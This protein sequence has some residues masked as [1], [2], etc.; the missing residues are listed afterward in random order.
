M[1][2]I[3]VESQVFEKFPDFA[4]G[5]IIVHDIENA[6]SNAIIEKALREEIAQEADKRSVDSELVRAW[7]AVHIAF[8]SNPNKFPPSIKS[9]LKRIDKKG[10]IPFINSA[11]ALFNYISIKYLV[12]CCGDDAQ[13][14][15]GNLR[16]GFAIG[17][18]AFAVGV[19]LVGLLFIVLPHDFVQVLQSLVQHDK[20]GIEGLAQRLILFPA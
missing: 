13:R 20:E 4:R 16:L 14:I 7:D 1:K 18:S 5:I 19:R 11:V 17:R 3:I 8:G 6:A 12:P 2:K 9:L 15:E 10:P